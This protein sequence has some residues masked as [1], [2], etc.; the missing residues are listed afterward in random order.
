M[1][2]DND[3]GLQIGDP[4]P[5]VAAPDLRGERLQFP[6]RC[7][8]GLV[9]V[10]F[11]PKAGTPGCV[12]QACSL[13][14][15]YPELARRGIDVIGVSGDRLE[16]QRRFQERRQLPYDLVSDRH[17]LV[18]KAFGVPCFLRFAKRQAFLFKDGKLVWKDLAASTRG[19][20]KDVLAAIDHL[21]AQGRRGPLR[22]QSN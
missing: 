22:N 15:A 2:D 4:V 10:F 8:R 3:I 17:C 13:R 14:D 20:A 19:Q 6:L 18:M 21:D 1:N 7:A 9:L 16:A 12:A 5:M 11:Y